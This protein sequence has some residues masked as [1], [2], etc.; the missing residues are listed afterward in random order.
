M[1]IIIIRHGDPDNPHQTLTPAGFKEVEA[2][3]EYL[4]DLEYTKVFC[5]PLP[6]AKITCNAV[7]KY[8]NDEPAILDWLQEFSYK[9]NVPYKKEQN[10]TWDLYPSYFKNND[11]FYLRDEGFLQDPCFKDTNVK[12][13]Y[14]EVIS[15]FD[16]ILKEY[17]Y[18]RDG[19]IY[20]VN[21]ENKDTLVFFCHLG[22]MSLLTSHLTDISY[23]SL[24]NS[25]FAP[26]SSITTFISEERQEGI[27]QFRLQGYG[28]IS[29]LSIKGLKPSYLG[30]F[31]EIYH[32]DDRHE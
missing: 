24:V 6:R 20:K 16:N 22:M 13:K 18:E 26:P 19:H 32:S 8:H 27:A 5:S 9:I 11:N 12:E 3:G 25:F 30:R 28:D 14:E 17:G 4:K 23:M 21:K 15:S 10:L 2:L 29:H 1:R 7:L 31:A